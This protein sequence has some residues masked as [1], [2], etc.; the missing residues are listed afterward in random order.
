MNYRGETDVCGDIPG[1]RNKGVALM[2][3]SALPQNEV[4]QW[5]VI[6]FVIVVGLLTLLML[7]GGIGDLLLLSGQS[8]FPSDIHRWHEAQSGVLTVIVFGGSLL[9]L[10]WR[11]LSKRLL[12]QFMILGIA[13]ACIAF[14]TV[15]GAGFNPIVLAIGGALIAI[16]VAAYPK[17]RD[18]M[19]VSRGGSLSY[20]LLAITLV[21]AIFLAPI[22]AREINYQMLGMTEHDIHALD[23]HWLTS[24]VLSLLLILAGLLAATKRPGWNM[25]GCVAGIAFLYLGSAALFLVDYAGSWGTTGGV[26]GILGGLGYIATTLVEVRRDRR[27]INAKITDKQSTS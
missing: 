4:K 24:V 27:A 18:L 9:A 20:P 10:L 3:S 12:V 8:G 25:L 15:T 1:S 23:Y 22:I 19:S 26:L 17:P 14:A 5:R 16:L 6:L 7:Y 2:S 11:P 13:I 21:A